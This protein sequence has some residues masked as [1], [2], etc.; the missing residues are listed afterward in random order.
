MATREF[1]PQSIKTAIR[2][3]TRW[4]TGIALQTWDRHGWR[5][6]TDTKILAVARP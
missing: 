3:R 4:V 5:G 1:F 2:Q 6:S